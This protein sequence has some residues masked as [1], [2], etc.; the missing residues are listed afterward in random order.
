LRVTLVNYRHTTSPPR[1]TAGWERSSHCIGR[2]QRGLE[3]TASYA[4][5]KLS[6]ERGHLGTGASGAS[7]GSRREASLRLGQAVR[8]ACLD[9][10]VSFGQL[11]DQMASG[12][13]REI[14][15]LSEK[16]MEAVHGS[17]KAS[18]AA[19]SAIIDRLRCKALAAFDPL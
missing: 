16:V 5:G 6:P 7:Q 12:A 10:Y 19:A 13:A 17:H 2:R 9:S 3:G 8:P 11:F 4:N 15:E 1:G 18:Y 14:V